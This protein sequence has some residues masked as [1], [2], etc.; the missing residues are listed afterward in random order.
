M[1]RCDKCRKTVPKSVFRDHVVQ[2]AIEFADDDYDDLV[3][4]NFELSIRT[5]L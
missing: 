1:H 5:L 4:H 2:L 3:D